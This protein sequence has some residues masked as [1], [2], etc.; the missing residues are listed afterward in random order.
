MHRNSLYINGPESSLLF[1]RKWIAENHTLGIEKLNISDSE[2]TCVV[3]FCDYELEESI[4]LPECHHCF[5]RDCL[6]TYLSHLKDHHEFPIKCLADS[7]PCLV[8]LELIR[9]NTTTQQFSD[10]CRAAFNAY[11]NRHGQ[12]CQFCPSPDCPQIYSVGTGKVKCDVCSANICSDCRVLY[13]EGLTCQEFSDF[14]DDPD[15]AAFFAWRRQNDVRKCPKVGCG[16]P[17]EKNGGCN[18]ITC[19]K[20]DSHICWVCMKVFSSGSPVYEHMRAEHGGIGI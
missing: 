12:D 7:C 16:A 20:C 1:I 9:E 8:P 5:C 15:E 10:L 18:H 4:R 14:K 19:R 13:H 17:I 3:C 11:V 2:K 6:K